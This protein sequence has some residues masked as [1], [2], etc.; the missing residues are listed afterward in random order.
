MIIL[1]AI[2][3]ALIFAFFNLSEVKEA[4]TSIHPSNNPGTIDDILLQCNN[5]LYESVFPV[6]WWAKSTIGITNNG[7]S[8]LHLEFKIGCN[9]TGQEISGF[10]QPFHIYLSPGENQTIF[11]EVAAP[12]SRINISFANLFVW[13]NFTRNVTLSVWVSGNTSAMKNLTIMHKIHIIPA[14][15]Y[16]SHTNA[17]I[18]GTVYD[19]FGKPMKATRVE[20][21]GAGPNPQFSTFTND[22]GQY[23]I[24]FT[25]IRYLMTNEIHAYCLLVDVTGYEKYLWAFWPVSEDSITRDVHLSRMSADVNCTLSSRTDTN[26]TVYRGSVTPDEQYV[27]FAQGHCQLNLNQSEIKKRS[28]V[29]FF[30]AING[31]LLWTYTPGGEIWTVDV[32]D[33]GEHVASAVIQTGAEEYGF[34]LDHNGSLMWDTRWIPED[35][36]SREVKISHNDT[37]YAYGTWKEVFLLNISDGGLRWNTS[38]EGQVRQMEFSSDDAR[39][40]VG[41]GDGYMYILNTDDGSIVNRTWIEAWPYSTGGMRLA[42][43]GSHIAT[44]SKIGNITLM[45][46]TTGEKL[47][48][49]DT[50]GGGKWVDISPDEYV[51]SGSGG[52]FGTSFIDFDGTLKW[53]MTGTSSGTIMSDGVTICT[54][55][56]WGFSIINPNGTNL[57]EYWEDFSSIPSPVSTNFVWVNKNMTKLIAGHGSGSIY[58]FNLTINNAP[59][60]DFDIVP[61]TGDLLTAFEFNATTTYDHENESSVLE[62][63]WDFNGDGIWDTTWSADKVAQHSYSSTGNYTVFLEV[64]DGNGMTSVA[65]RNVSVGN[66]IPEF[67]TLAIPIGAAITCFYLARFVS[68]RRVR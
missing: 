44:I 25:A 27:A 11:Y 46:A 51:I 12:D 24:N 1:G 49:F 40:Y 3:G 34:L 15:W 58:F 53:F 7:S 52:A 22:T 16:R 26:M 39:L 64:R 32:S 66:V 42:D 55:T 21:Y 43:D 20:V 35:P 23:R 56:D 4:P 13:G 36:G 5:T 30:N 10:P 59:V 14:I 31:S 67:N 18:S 45:N 2:F 50:R 65:T 8:Y 29:L 37:Y 62:I 41:S 61:P 9:E 38:V 17:T 60:A 28:S 19:E 48:S 63:R 68:R 57:Y 54:G 6:E 33:N 47:W